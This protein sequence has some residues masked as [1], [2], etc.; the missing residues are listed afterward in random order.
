LADGLNWF[1]FPAV[2]PDGDLLVQ[3]C[4]FERNQD[5]GLTILTYGSTIGPRAVVRD[6]RFLHNRGGG[7]IRAWN[8]PTFISQ[9]LFWDNEG[10]FTGGIQCGPYSEVHVVNSTFV[11]NRATTTSPTGTEAGGASCPP[12]RIRNSI[13]VAN[14]VVN[15][16]LGD[17]REQVWGDATNRLQLLRSSCVQGLS[18]YAGADNVLAGDLSEFED[19]ARG[20][21]RLAGSS[22]CID[23]GD[24]FVDWD[25]W[26]VGLQSPPWGD[27]EWLPRVVDGDGD[28]QTVIDAGAHE[29]Q[30]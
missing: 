4:T 20:N 25:P 16:G 14:S 2:S 29:Y 27:I 24:P 7:A 8:T 18:F 6:S 17:D 21:L 3:G 15:G 26:A 19:G 22:S 1:V 30:P 5:T 11:G 12:G 9:G 28:G 13:F 23:V 10:S